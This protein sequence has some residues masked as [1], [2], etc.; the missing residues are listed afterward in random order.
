MGTIKQAIKEHVRFRKQILVLAKSELIK[1]YSGTALGWAWAII[2]PVTTIF[3]FW[4]AFTIG[5]RSGKPVEG[6]P[7]F[8]W[9]V[10][11]FVPWFYMSDCLSG[12]S[13][14]ILRQKYLVTKLKFPMTV[15]PT[16]YNLSE[17]YVHGVLLVLTIILF[18][19]F[20]YYPDKYFLQLPLYMIM[21]FVGFVIW[22]LLAGIISCISKD[23]KNLI[24]SFSRAIF[25]TSGV[26]FNID[27]IDTA[28]IRIIL[29]LNPIAVITSGYRNVFIYKKW[30]FETQNDMLC[31]LLTNT[32]FL[33]LAIRAYNKLRKEIPDVI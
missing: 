1:K 18:A 10:A 4:F 33:I 13:T 27:N 12:G 31:W 8:L 23:F 32:I 20:G 16:F 19:L 30:F 22:G 11:G 26:F 7:Y 2:K 6:Y 9:L 5:L 17:F 24:A 25:W 28:W 21:M 14:C 15:I 29:K 3:I